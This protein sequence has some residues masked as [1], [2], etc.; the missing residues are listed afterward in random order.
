M[1]GETLDL[2][3]PEDDFPMPTSA[4][5]AALHFNSCAT[6][7]PSSSW[8]QLW[9]GPPSSGGPDSQPPSSRPLLRTHTAV[10][11]PLA[12]PMDCSLSP[13]VCAAGR[14]PSHGGA[15]SPARS[16][17]SI[18]TVAGADDPLNQALALSDNGSQGA[19]SRAL[20][21]GIDFAPQGHILGES[22][23]TA[24][25]TAI[26]TAAITATATMTAG[27]ATGTANSNS[28]ARRR[29]MS[30][31]GTTDTDTTMSRSA[32]AGTTGT[33]D[34]TRGIGT[35]IGTTPLTAHTMGTATVTTSG[36]TTTTLTTTTET[37][38]AATTIAT[39]V[40]Q[41]A[42]TDA[43]APL[44][45]CRWTTTTSTTTS[46]L[47]DSPKWSGRSPSGHGPCKSCK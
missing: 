13:H 40:T 33:T 38:T 24:T 6:L 29:R 25:A 30:T 36:T 35:A 11:G 4:R 5:G 1:E 27:T 2:C 34:T 20:G 18:G 45:R 39:S 31:T 28:N 32:T 15:P 8:P 46:R 23:A 43:P 9:D 21:S 26:T 10:A 3:L 37:T 44:L 41:G 42:R 7:G 14:V 12:H 16:E 22:A 17:L 19:L 47:R